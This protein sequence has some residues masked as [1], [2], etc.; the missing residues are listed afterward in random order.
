M[1]QTIT[2]IH[3]YS[4]AELFHQIGPLP[5]H[6]EI[7]LA[8]SMV[9]ILPTTESYLQALA[10]TVTPCIFVPNKATRSATDIAAS[11]T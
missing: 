11:F 5:Q 9:G 8:L 2:S 10:T 6:A 7:R 1:D 3:A 4:Y